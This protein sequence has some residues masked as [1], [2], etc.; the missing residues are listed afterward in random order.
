MDWNFYCKKCGQLIELEYGMT[1]TYCNGCNEVIK[2]SDIIDGHTREARINQLKLMHKLMI[3]AN[4][5][6][7]YFTWILLMPDC[8]TEMDFM[9][10][11]IDDEQYNKCFDLFV[12]LIADKGNRH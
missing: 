5:E 4:D 11:A 10:I 3:E 12:K 1:E 2:K 7:I 9:E 8:P 6:N